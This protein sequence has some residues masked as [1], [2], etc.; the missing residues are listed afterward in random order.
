[1]LHPL[2]ENKN[3]KNL[4]MQKNFLANVT[5]DRPMAHAVDSAAA[6]VNNISVS[7]LCHGFELFANGGSPN[8]LVDMAASHHR[9]NREDAMS[10]GKWGCGLASDQLRTRAISHC[11]HTKL[12]I[13]SKGAL[14]SHTKISTNKNF[15]LYSTQI[16]W[17]KLLQ[18]AGKQQNL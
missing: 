4:N 9:F 17:R 18:V 3:Y 11:K 14:V 5:F 2:C 8:T 6:N 12:K 10:L 1:M 16:S 13:Y 7:V 15:P